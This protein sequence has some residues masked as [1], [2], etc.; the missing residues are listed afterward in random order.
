MCVQCMIGAVSAGTAATGVRSV[1]A[2]KLASW[3]SPARM[4]LIS[5][6]LIAVAVVLASTVLSGGGA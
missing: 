6:T 4:R 3:I 2:V 1:V 5:G